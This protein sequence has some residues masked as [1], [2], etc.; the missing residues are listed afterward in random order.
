MAA[1]KQPIKKK[2]LVIENGYVLVGRRII[3]NDAFMNQI[4]VARL[5]SI[6]NSC[7]QLKHFHNF[8]LKLY[9]LKMFV[10][11]TKTNLKN[12]T[13]FDRFADHH[14]GLVPVPCTIDY[15]SI[16]PASSHSSYVA[17]CFLY[18]CA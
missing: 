17:V 12:P 3:R 14:Q 10:M 4:L 16:F 5:L 13:C 11:R 8:H 6:A 2:S 7:T 18:V 1:D 9:T 15:L